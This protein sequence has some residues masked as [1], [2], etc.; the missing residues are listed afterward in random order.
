MT[1]TTYKSPV[2]LCFKPKWRITRENSLS[3]AKHEAKT[4]VPNDMA[5]RRQLA[6][7]SS[8]GRKS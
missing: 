8:G 5:L 7:Q 4:L 1:V 2:F 3:S 6:T